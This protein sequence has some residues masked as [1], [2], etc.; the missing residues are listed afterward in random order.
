MD[1]ELVAE[2]RVLPLTLGTSRSG[3][4]QRSKSRP[5]ILPGSATLTERFGASPAS[6]FR[7]E[8][9]EPYYK[10]IIA[11]SKAHVGLGA[12]H[13][14]ILPG[15]VVNAEIITGS[16]SLVRYL[17]KPVFRSLDIAFTER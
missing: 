12:Q 4:L 1:D 15:M 2:V 14:S 13:H 7:D 9:D 6:T 16:K 3:I 10:V 17:L 5:T 11:L 8:Q